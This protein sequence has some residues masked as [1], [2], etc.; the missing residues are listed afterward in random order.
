MTAVVGIL[1]ATGAIGGGFRPICLAALATWV[2]LATRSSTAL[3]DR[4]FSR[5]H[6]T[7]HPDL[8][9]EVGSATDF[10]REIEGANF[11]AVSWDVN[12][13]SANNDD[14]E[15]E[16]VVTDV[17]GDKWD[18]YLA[19]S[20]RGTPGG[21]WNT[22]L[23]R[24]SWV[25]HRTTAAGR[26]RCALAAVLV[27][28]ATAGCSGPPGNSLVESRCTRCHNLDVVRTS[29][30]TAALW[31]LTVDRM[32]LRGATLDDQERTLVIDYL[33]KQYP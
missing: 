2:T 26:L 3:K 19:L 24:N 30:K 20:A 22:S 4:D 33:S 15:L 12:S 7:M 17:D 32:I 31:E 28:A 11:S 29:S 23:T 21:W 10:Q 16:G 13:T 1:A 6:G 14:G 8:Q 25:D 5:A 9:V 27:V 18:F